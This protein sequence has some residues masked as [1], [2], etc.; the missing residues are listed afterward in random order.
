MKK[1]LTIIVS[2]FLVFC[3][4]AKA[5]NDIIK[6]KFDNGFTYY[7]YKTKSNLNKASVYFIQKAGAFLEE[8]NEDGLAHFLEHMAFNGTKHFP[9]NTIGK[10]FSRY[11]IISGKNINAYTGIDQTVYYIN[12]IPTNNQEAMMD[13]LNLASDWSGDILLN[14]KDVEEERPVIIE[15]HR[16]TMKGNKKKINKFKIA[17]YN[18]NRYSHRS[19]IGDIN[20]IKNFKLKTIK[21]FYV[22]WYR[23]DMQCVLVY[24]D[25]NVKKIK[26]EIR[27][28][29][30]NKPLAK[31]L[32][33]VPSFDV[34]NHDE[35]LFVRYKADDIKRTSYHYELRMK[36]IYDKST[37]E[38]KNYVLKRNLLTVMMKKDIR[39]MIQDPLVPFTILDAATEDLKADYDIV[40]FSII[41][42]ANKDA[43][44]IEYIASYINYIKSGLLSET[45]FEAEKKKGIDIYQKQL[46]E[47]IKSS[48][49]EILENIK[50]E[51]INGHQ[52]RNKKQE[53]ELM[54]SLIKELSFEDFNKYIQSLDFSRN[55]YVLMEGNTNAD[56]LSDM[57]IKKALSSKIKWKPIE[58]NETKTLLKKQVLPIVEIEKKRI[59]K[60]GVVKYSLPNNMR[61]FYKKDSKIKNRVLVYGKSNGGSSAIE[62]DDL[63]SSLFVEKAAI[64]GL[65]NLNSIEYAK[66]M[67]KNKLKSKIILTEKK[68]KIQATCSQAN[69]E[70]LMKVIYAQFEEPR[71]DENI[72]DE[73]KAAGIITNRQTKSLEE[74]MQDDLNNV[75]LG[76]SERIIKFN[77]EFYE[78]LNLKDIERVYK[79]RICDASDWVFYITAN[80]KEEDIETYL[81]K[82]LSNIKDIVRDDKA[83]NHPNLFP[84]GY[85]KKIYE[86]EA[87]DKKAI[88][89]I[90]YNK[91]IEY[92]NEEEL[93]HLLVKKYLGKEL[94]RLVREKEGGTYAVSVQQK[95][96]KE[97]DGR[98]VTSI[99][100]LCDPKRAQELKIKMAM[101]VNSIIQ[102][103]LPK[104]FFNQKINQLREKLIQ[105]VKFKSNWMV[106]VEAYLK[107]EEY[108]KTA[109]HKLKT[110]NKL[111]LE[112][113]NEI[114]HE[115]FTNADILD[116]CFK[117]KSKKKIQDVR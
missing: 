9:A 69:I 99:Q 8:D 95:Y 110:I 17:Q 2:V 74:Q 71:F 12:N 90:V 109:Q 97:K 18:N 44:S 101:L 70:A 113:L 86:Y 6:G 100:F 29:F 25:V 52:Y 16:R 57:E 96:Q 58:I 55:S 111:K 98:L 46:S 80:I 54:I 105:E 22:K 42:K 73:Y 56:F 27:K 107:K 14:Q 32:P 26:E 104:Q 37:K 49:K 77:N 67:A 40:R 103:G 20:V 1:V 116:I 10:H 51:F 68:E 21:D 91:K 35:L 94:T 39:R 13:A 33:D 117:S 23:P 106:E 81:Q 108:T 85:T 7:I 72:L 114:M 82:Y 59:P 76:E 53:A 48:E 5:D 50:A 75:L 65:G 28:R 24:G 45:Q 47:N 84:K 36:N 89:L 102:S 43:E 64:F 31:V 79:S 63:A 38:Y 11:G 93:S 15:E 88:N 41:P 30:E 87:V 92:T 34:D 83:L 112:R 19:V 115:Y 3:N 62:T 78:N 4:C 66:Y 60:H 61:V